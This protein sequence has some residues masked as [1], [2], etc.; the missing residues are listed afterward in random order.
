MF[1]ADMGPRPAG[2]TLDRIDNDKDYAPGNCR[3]ASASQQQRNKKTNRLVEW[4]GALIPMQ[5]L[6][7]K[8][9]VPYGLL[10]DRIVRAGWTT[11]KAVATKKRVWPSQP[12][13][14]N[15]ARC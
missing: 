13:P 10:Y 15:G 1:L 2:T 5:S 3:W 12:S 7:D 6:S 8:T 4:R 9:G 11:E 14:R